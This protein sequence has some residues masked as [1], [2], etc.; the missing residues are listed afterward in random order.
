MLIATK[1][2]GHTFAANMHW[3]RSKMT[4]PPRVASELWSGAHPS[5]GCPSAILP[6]NAWRLDQQYWT[7]PFPIHASTAP[8][9]QRR[10]AT[11]HGATFHPGP[12]TGTTINETPV[13]ALN[14]ASC[15]DAALIQQRPD[16]TSTCDVAGGITPCSAGCIADASPERGC[17]PLHCELYLVSGAILH[18]LQMSD[19]DFALLQ[20]HEHGEIRVYVT[21]LESSKAALLQATHTPPAKEAHI[22]RSVTVP[23]PS[24][25]A[26]QRPRLPALGHLPPGHCWDP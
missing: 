14:G 16:E 17:R 19:S 26:Q 8:Q 25:G 22:L 6:A 10:S 4:M 23:A 3:P 1:Q 13:W 9:T 15:D 20:G 7:R 11:D 18:K 2:A 5:V 21:A 24:L 12:G